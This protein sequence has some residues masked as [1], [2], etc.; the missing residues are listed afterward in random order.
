MEAVSVR[1]AELRDREALC[2]LYHDFHEYHVRGVPDRLRS[3]G[4][5]PHT[6]VGSELYQV[7]TKIIQDDN[8]VIFLAQVAQ[9]T[10]GLVEVYLRQDEPNPLRV[11]H[12]YGYLQSLMVDERFRR[13]GIGTRLVEAAHRWAQEKGA[14]EVRLEIWEF[15]AGPLEFYEQSGYRTLRRTLVREL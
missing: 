3:L 8:A 12:R 11:S 6:Y 13:R 4:E 9:R 15:K 7:L 10:V 1:S 5:P 14:A 2:S